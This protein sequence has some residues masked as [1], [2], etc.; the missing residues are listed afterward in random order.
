M[1]VVVIRSL[2]HIG[3]FA[4]GVHARHCC[5]SE[6]H[7]VL[8]AC[9]IRVGG[10]QDSPLECTRRVTPAR[11]VVVARVPHHPRMRLRCVGGCHRGGPRGTRGSLQRR[12]RGRVDAQRGLEHLR[13]GVHVVRCCVQW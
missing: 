9:V 6:E 11:V 5:P 3:V 7:G 8:P 1:C 10:A 2:V 4:C 13:A 12:G